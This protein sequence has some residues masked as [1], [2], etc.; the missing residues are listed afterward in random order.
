MIK[1]IGSLHSVQIEGLAFLALPRRQMVQLYEVVQYE[2]PL[3][4]GTTTTMQEASITSFCEML[5]SS[6]LAN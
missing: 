6:R 4:H 3:G 2:N 5:P 1:G